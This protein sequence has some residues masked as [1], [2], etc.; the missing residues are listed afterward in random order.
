MVLQ[1]DGAKNLA[2]AIEEVTSDGSLFP[3]RK[4]RE[5]FWKS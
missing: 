3:L 2:R 4:I 5:F 1:G